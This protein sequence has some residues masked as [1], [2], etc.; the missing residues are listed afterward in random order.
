MRK[1]SLYNC[2]LCKLDFPFEKIMY[3]PDG[4]R[5][6]CSDCCR[7]YKLKTLSEQDSKNTARAKFE[8]ETKEVKKGINVI[9]K[10]CRY[11]FVLRI[12]KRKKNICPYC[13]KANLMRDEGI[14]QK[15]LDDVS[16]NQ[17]AYL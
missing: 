2:S 11:K 15:I 4:K 14:A 16:K 17:N 12:I 7:V 3:A 13:G 6:I 1:E 9:C 10:E 5:L 8:V